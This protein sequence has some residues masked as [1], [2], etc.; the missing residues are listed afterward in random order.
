MSIEVRIPTILRTYTGGEKAVSGEGT[1]LAELAL[2]AA[3]EPD[4]EAIEKLAQGSAIGTVVFDPGF[5]ING[6]I[7]DIVVATDGEK[8]RRWAGDPGAFAPEAVEEYVRCFADP[9]AIHASCED[10]R[11]AAT[12]DL[13][14]D[15]ADI[16][17]LLDC[18]VLV[19]WG[20]EGRLPAAFG[21]LIEV[22]R[23]RARQVTGRELPCGHFPPEERPEETAA[24]LERFLAPT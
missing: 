12:I 8:L 19:L 4:T 7:A 2:L 15:E 6:A 1:T 10:Y 17:R 3:D 21:D 16:E 14:H 18:P 24:E 5:V 20:S 11:A 13:E 9:A 22:W 23:T